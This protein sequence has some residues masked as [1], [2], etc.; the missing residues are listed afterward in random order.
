MPQSP[1]TAK[2][3]LGIIYNTSMDRPDAPLALAL[4]YGFESKRDSRMGSVCVVG[5]GLKAAIYCDIVAKFFQLGS[6]RNANQLLPVGLAAADPLPPDP[7]MVQPVV[8]GQ[9]PHTVKRLSDT[10]LAEAVIRNGVIFNS[11]AAVI[12]SAPATYLAKSLDLL[13]TEELYKERV[14]RLVV[15]DNGAPQRDP[16][17][18]RKVIASWPTPVFYCGPEAGEQAIF[19][20]SAIEKD[21]AWSTA[22]PIVEAYRAYKAMPY[23]APGW[24]IAAAHYAV[25]PDSG[26]FGVSEAGTLSVDE[27]GR[28]RF[29]V[30]GEGTVRG[31]SVVPEKRDELMGAVVAMV[32]AKPVPPQQRFRPPS[33]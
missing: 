18:L 21:F 31:L 14:R 24:D 29:A 5:S 27:Q 4:L 22:H 2:P 26:F 19:P 20:G 6:P 3:P 15:V 11:D 7:P 9:Y 30:G 8:D 12:L 32:S 33:K 1:F 10:A 25:H 16:A 13:G 28:M 23:D 17:S